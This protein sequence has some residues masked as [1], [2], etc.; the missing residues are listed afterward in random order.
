MSDLFTYDDLVMQDL[1]WCVKMLLGPTTHLRRA[2][3]EQDFGGTDGLLV[4][5]HCVPIQLRARFDRPPASEDCDITFR[6]TEPAMIAAGTYAPLSVYAWFR[7]KRL[8]AARCVDVYRLAACID[9][10]FSGRAWQPNRDRVHTFCTVSFA[11]LWDARALLKIFD[12]HW[13][14]TGNGDGQ[15]R[16][17]QIIELYSKTNGS[18]L[19]A[20][21]P[22]VRPKEKRA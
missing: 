18:V 5:N 15:Q 14:A 11:E 13:W 12:G 8:M 20:E 9:P 4:A 6:N 21:K 16:L 22:D 3:Q 2:T 19:P 7:A 1:E 17:M 10:P